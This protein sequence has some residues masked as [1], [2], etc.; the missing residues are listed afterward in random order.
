[1]RPRGHG[2]AWHRVWLGL[3]RLAGSFC[4]CRPVREM[5]KRQR[6][7]ER[8]V[9]KR[10]RIATWATA[11]GSSCSSLAWTN[12]ARRKPRSW[13]H[14]ILRSTLGRSASAIGSGYRLSEQAA[15]RVTRSL[16]TGEQDPL[17]HFAGSASRLCPTY[18]CWGTQGAREQS[19]Q[20]A[21]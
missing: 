7:R 16:L 10:S 3:G 2:A 17:K 9:A 6:G 19:R 8:A 1:M 4:C 12:S 15:E 21:P 11:A 14:A 13:F 20:P 18:R 5:S